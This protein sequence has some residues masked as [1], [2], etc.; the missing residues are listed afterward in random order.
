MTGAKTPAFERHNHNSCVAG[1]MHRVQES[2]EA[3]NLRLTPVRK[4]VLELLLEEHR[5]MGAYDI[6]ERLSAEN[7][8]SQPPIA[9]RALDFLVTHGFAH[10]LQHLN[11]FIACGHP[12]D[13]HIPVFMICRDCNS[14][15]EADIGGGMTAID[16][17]ADSL[18]FKIERR[19]IEAEGIC[20]A[21]QESPAP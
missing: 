3:Q 4:R 14:V 1:A 15:A 6:L 10:K 13:A 12:H 8:G 21:C 9:Y 19:V 7:M 5:A 20:P 11:A 17:A 18:G 2:C 16:R